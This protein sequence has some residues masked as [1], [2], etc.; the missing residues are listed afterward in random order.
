M[1]TQ[2]ETDLEI[3]FATQA[4]CETKLETALDS[5]P[6]AHYAQQLELLQDEVVGMVSLL[7]VER[8]QKESLA[9]QVEDS[10]QKIAE[11]TADNDGLRAELANKEHEDEVVGLVSLLRVER[12]QK[13]SLAEK[14]DGSIQEVNQ[15]MAEHDRLQ[16]ELSNSKNEFEIALQDKDD[17]FAQI[18]EALRTGAHELKEQA[19][20]A[21][22]DL[23]RM[24]E[25]NQKL[26]E[27]RTRL[28]K[29]AADIEAEF[30]SAFKTHELMRANFEQ[31]LS[32]AEEGK[33]QAEI[34]LLKTETQL[35]KSRKE[36]EGLTELN[37]ML[38]A[39]C[40]ALTSYPVIKAELDRKNDDAQK[41][42]TQLH[43]E[44]EEKDIQIRKLEDELEEHKQS[45]ERV[46]NELDKMLSKAEET[47]KQSEARLIEQLDDLRRENESKD[48]MIASLQAVV[49]EMAQSQENSEALINA[50][51]DQFKHPDEVNKESEAPYN[52]LKEE[53][54]P[55][56]SMDAVVICIDVSASMYGNTFKRAIQTYELLIEGIIS[57]NPSTHVG[58]LT[59]G[60]NS[61][62]VTEVQKLS[63][64]DVSMR[65]LL[66]DLDCGGYS[67]DYREVLEKAQTMLN[68]FRIDHPAAALRIITIGDYSAPFSLLR[69]DIPIDA[70]VLHDGR[71]SELEVTEEDYESDCLD[72][73]PSISRDT[74][75]KC[76]YLATVASP[77]LL[78]EKLL[79]R[80]PP[81]VRKK[82]AQHSTSRTKSPHSTPTQAY[83]D[84]EEELPAPPSRVSD[85]F[86]ASTTKKSSY[87]Y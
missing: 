1:S 65:R 35:Q 45:H 49:S 82:L 11:L 7:R 72:V 74:G 56:C 6:P 14:L 71:D 32:A 59:H 4:I 13:E 61:Y 25:E 83:A 29:H 48:S 69:Q 30:K 58:L 51:L 86:G 55:R 12:D 20:A 21:K 33:H 75:G 84:S 23:H 70:I 80:N 18:R 66:E 77:S 19:V 34:Q 39:K 31:N 87:Y 9:R 60:D 28:S 38:E 2:A 64:V 27:D 43:K 85:L 10:I 24:R 17:H 81:V 22:S 36:V 78:V 76:F 46:L 57:R 37:S 52:E 5:S 73:V 47:H 67:E 68:T 44:N 16:A 42:L 79:G 62:H 3:A 50:L 41:R 40:V 15:L 63:P 53:E 26:S 54:V 8:E